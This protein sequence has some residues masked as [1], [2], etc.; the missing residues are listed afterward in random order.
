[1]S[2]PLPSPTAAALHAALT[3]AGSAAA[4]ADLCLEFLAAGERALE[5]RHDHGA[6]GLEIAGARAA[7]AD[8]LLAAVFA[9]HPETPPAT[10]IVARGHY[11]QATLNPHS[12]IR[13]SLVAAAPEAPVGALVD[14]L[15]QLNL[16][17][18]LAPLSTADCLALAESDPV[19]KISLLDARWVA[20]NAALCREL[21][22]AVARV[23]LGTDFIATLTREWHQ[24]HQRFFNTVFLQE[25]DVLESCGGLSDYHHLGWVCRIKH[26][27]SDLAALVES[28]LLTVAAH[29]EISAAVEFLHRV[30]NTLHYHTRARTDQLTLMLQGVVAAA[31]R[32]P[33]RGV[34]RRTEA[35]MRDYYRHTLALQ[36]HVGELMERS[37]LVPEQ[38]ADDGLR[39]FLTF[40]TKPEEAFDGFI[41]RDG[42]I[43]PAAPDVL[44]T[45]PHRLMRLFQHCQVR[46][47]R[48]SP[49]LLQLVRARLPQIDRAYRCAKANRET[50][51]AILERKGDVAMT[52]RK[53]HRCGFLGRYLPEFA[54]LDCLV[55]HE[56]F[57]RFSADEHTLRC[58][59]NL[60]HLVGDT[61]PR[62]E[63][64]RR[65]FHE[66]ADPYALYL[67]VILH[68]TGRA[69]NVAEH[70]D[71]SAVLATRLCDRLHVGGS[72]RTLIRF[73]V[74]EHLSFWRTATTRNLED[75]E[76][77]AEFA[78]RV[79]NRS[80]LDALFLFTYA[81]S[82]ATSPES[83]T[84][85]KESLMLQLYSSTRR[86]L[87]GG[88]RAEYARQLDADRLALRGEV[89]ALMR[90]DYHPDIDRHF[91]RMPAAAFHFRQAPQ[92]VTQVR[93]V[94][95]FLQA[96]EAKSAPFAHCVKWIDH[97]G[98]GYSEL[99]L[100]TRDKPLLLEKLCCAL[101]ACQLNILSADFFTRTD[102]IVVDLFRVCTTD[103]E[104]VADVALRQRFLELFAAILHAATYEPERQFQRPAVSPP[105]R[106]AV[107]VEAYVTNQLH[108]TCTTVEI[109]AIDRIG[110][111][112]DLF[113]VINQ[114]GLTTAHARICTERG[115]AMD[116]LYITTA[117][118]EKVT[119][120][121]TLASLN[122]H[123]AAVIG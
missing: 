47:L 16:R 12:E 8:E 40:R 94:R 61:D 102:G 76:V 108:P 66:I 14:S 22:D 89:I 95:H 98:K 21:T 11:G 57:H 53:M 44:E 36:Q 118:G 50:F 80:N 24:R 55:Q 15:A 100:A 65:L 52:L 73:L 31:F 4:R 6:G 110:V 93:T 87:D 113:H 72:R 23:S 56:F 99:I 7:L 97:P 90:P 49:E 88:D 45:D 51:Q 19:F 54:P 29:Q 20:G 114:H 48:L 74:D 41:A 58:V 109:Q 63:I 18:S 62:R 27:T 78:A 83:W 33:Q 75:P 32:Y 92:L 111:L 96:E 115:V 30:R 69:V 120:P 68:D 104:P 28:G 77:I 106:L 119:D 9:S 10:A 34:L 71:G 82:N 112:H 17:L 123:L 38:R 35:L 103:F 39:S 42:R 2:V 13:I 67:A 79:K 101:A 5:S 60:D 37:A 84:G 122:E 105:A 81:D 117:S 70:I 91:E 26:G 121:A 86:F 107:P 46:Q 116:T 43:H 85:W 59:D 25:P 64:F 3:H 1:M